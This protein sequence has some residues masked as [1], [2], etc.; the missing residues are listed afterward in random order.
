MNEADRTRT[1]MAWLSSAAPEP[2]ACRW[3]WERHPMGVALLP[4]GRIWDVLILPGTLGHPTFDVLTRVLDRP[5]P[6]AR[7]PSQ[8]PDRL[9][10][11]AG[12]GGPLAGHGGARGGPRQLDRGA[13]PGAH[14]ERRPL[15]DP[16]RRHRGAHRPGRPRTRH[17]RGRGGRGAG[18]GGLNARAY[19]C[20]GAGGRGGS[21]AV[22]SRSRTAARPGGCGAGGTGPEECGSLAALATGY[23]RTAG[24]PGAAPPGAVSASH[25]RTFSNTL[26][27]GS[28]PPPGCPGPRSAGPRRSPAA[29]GSAARSRRCRW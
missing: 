10:R 5:G 3:E 4:A 17:A 9:L 14:G 19:H 18:A 28:R 11:A 2:D 25:P 6:G 26:T 15:A 22:P 24:R 23:D 20:P 27:G 8:P 13:A 29:A 21:G 16:A 1:A 12:H 7:R